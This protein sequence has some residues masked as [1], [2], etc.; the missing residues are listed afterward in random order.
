MDDF[1]IVSAGEPHAPV[2]EVHGEIDVATAPQLTTA[3][4]EIVD[5]GVPW[6]LVDLAAVSFIDSSGMSALV[7]ADLKAKALGTHLRIRNA[8]GVA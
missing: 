1:R 3:I 2:L 7:R 8:T 4:S 5:R 6:L